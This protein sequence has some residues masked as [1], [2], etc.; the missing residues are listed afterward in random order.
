[1]LDAY[2]QSCAYDPFVLKAFLA[3]T[4]LSEI[5]F[6]Q[7]RTVVGS[8]HTNKG[9]FPHGAIL[10]APGDGDMRLRLGETNR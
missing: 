9:V 4:S 7:Q 5:A 8:F 6:T 10:E 3:L 2:E 1:M